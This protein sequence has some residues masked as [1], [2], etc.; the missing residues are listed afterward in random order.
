MISERV[1]YHFNSRPNENSYY[2]QFLPQLGEQK[3]EGSDDTSI[4]IN[5]KIF[6]GYRNLAI[7]IPL[8]KT[9]QCISNKERPNQN[10]TIYFNIT[11]VHGWF[12]YLRFS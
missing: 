8:F 4:V 3:R 5:G 1:C 10:N 12:S 11:V 9:L 7:G 6:E 2:C